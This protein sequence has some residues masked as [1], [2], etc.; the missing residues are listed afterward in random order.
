MI[1][2][3][4][5]ALTRGCN[6]R[7][8]TGAAAFAGLLLLSFLI[9]CS[10][11]KEDSYKTTLTGYAAKGPLSGAAV[12][13]YATSQSGAR[14]AVL[15]QTTTS[16]DGT[17]TVSFNPS[18]AIM[19]VAVTGGEYRDE[20]TGAVIGLSREMRALIPP[21][22][23]QASLV[24]TP[25]THMAA[26][27]GLAE[28]AKGRSAADAIA[29]AAWNVGGQFG[30]T[31]VDI[32]THRPADLSSQSADPASPQAKY[33]LALAAL[34]ASLRL[35]GMGPDQMVNVIANL[36]ADFGNGALDG[37]TTN[38]GELPINMHVTPYQLVAS[39]GQAANSFLSG[40]TNRSGLA[41]GAVAFSTSPSATPPTTPAPSAIPKP[42][43][44]PYVPPGG[45]GGGGGGGGSGP[46]IDAPPL[47][48]TGIVASPGSGFAAVM[49]NAA[50][51]ATSYNV[52]WSAVPGTGT[53]GT[54]V[55]GVT[56]PH[57]VSGLANGTV[58]YF[59]VTAQ[60]SYGESAASVEVSAT[61]QE[62]AGMGTPPAAP[63]GVA[64]TAGEGTLTVTWNSVTNALTYNVYR[65]TY[66]GAGKSAFKFPSVTS[67]FTDGGLQN[68]TTYYY[69]V[70]AVNTAGESDGSTEVFGRPDIS[71]SSINFAD[72][73]LRACVLATGLTYA[74]Q[75]TGLFCP[76]RNI[77]N[78]TGINNLSRLT[79]LDI[80][81][82]NISD[83]S[84]LGSLPLLQDLNA[85][86]SHI[87]SGVAT[88]ANNATFLRFLDITGNLGIPC[89][90]LQS[91]IDKVNQINQGMGI[92]N[93]EAA[94]SGANCS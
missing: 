84:I 24:V 57:I 54:K 35:W 16:G 13:V 93:P 6:S 67:P 77:S 53:A 18:G 94:L 12:T 41:P 29:I 15:G 59:V 8:R 63:Q 5:A 26:D 83:I 43:F 11:A 92:V 28:L 71:L 19:E 32:T 23:G 38:G 14:E 90:D 20:A 10:G 76:S 74:S 49:W 17:F 4:T 21:L 88:L 85:A 56:S 52:Y 62:G 47:A 80:S 69:V 45:G 60:N 58:Y 87:T 3:A 46:G 31:G 81:G 25:L 82:N 27:F 66:S 70:T 42:S 36:A 33:G 64:I 7:G 44:G 55:S 86:N 40:A 72:G 37:V 91:L 50:S 61:P 68:G 51:G 1:P 75:M 34:S 2:K 89:A 65:S 73:A 48:P 39:L 9:Q 22:E 30:M 79:D 78:L